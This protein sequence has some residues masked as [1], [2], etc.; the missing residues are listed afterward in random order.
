MTAD[1]KTNFKSCVVMDL[2][3]GGRLG[4]LH[5]EFGQKLGKNMVGIRAKGN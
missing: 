3:P 1:K 2:P 4:V 5:L